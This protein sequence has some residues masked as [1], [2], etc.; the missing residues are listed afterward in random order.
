MSHNL[1]TIA[2][3][4]ISY[5]ALL[6]GCAVAPV[7]APIPLLL[8][9][10]DGTCSGTAIGPHAVL[11]ATHCFDG[12]TVKLDG[13]T[14]KQRVDDGDDHTILIVAQTFH[15]HAEI[16]PMPAAGADVHINGNPADLRGIYASG[17]VAGEYDGDTLLNLPIYYG[18]SGAAVLDDA[19]H[20]VGVISGIRVLAGGGVIVE[21]AE[22]KPFR[23]TAAQ[24]REALQ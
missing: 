12:P 3:L 6:C 10:S 8:T 20:V 5:V 2:L 23:F 9:F 13:L 18:D 14:V 4:C 11:T 7:T 22:T 16:A 21:W 1:Y 19:G 24:W 17:T 15:A